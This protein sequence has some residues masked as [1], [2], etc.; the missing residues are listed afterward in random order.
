MAGEIE[1]RL[2]GDNSHFVSMLGDSERQA[3]RAMLGMLKKFD[4]RAGTMAI[5][6]AIG[7]NMQ[8]IADSVARAFTSMGK[9]AEAS[10]KSLLQLSE[11]TAKSYEQLFAARRTDAQNINMLEKENN[12]LANERLEILA[13]LE[14]RQKAVDEL[15]R[16]QEA[17]RKSKGGGLFSLGITN[18]EAAKITEAEKTRLEEIKNAE[19]KN[20]M[21]IEELRR[22]VSEDKK[23]AEEKRANDNEKEAEKEKRAEKEA[24]EDALRWADERAMLEARIAEQKYDTLSTE[25]KITAKTAEINRLTAEKMKMDKD[26]NDFLKVQVKI[27]E[28]NREL[29]EQ[30]AALAREKLGL[31]KEITSEITQQINI[32]G[33]GNKELSDRELD[34]KIST[35][36]KELA[37]TAVAPAAGPLGDYNP[38]ASM[39]RLDLERAIDEQRLRDQ[40]RR[41]VLRYGE[42]RAFRMSNLSE[43]RFQD[44][45]NGLQESLIQQ[46]ETN[47]LLKGGLRTL[48]MQTNGGLG[49]G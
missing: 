24:F 19:V 30:Q 46:R 10:L 41:N 27:N 26:S 20:M 23:R 44:I 3:D 33:R 11:Q 14:S 34:R 16:S 17:L 28:A 18:A 39:Q 6:T 15:N 37:Q 1:V 38:L 43:F 45:V 47:R 2:T 36:R 4:L 40:T 12:R 49:N 42:D 22:K 29:A 32:R 48:P 9:E 21:V 7:L 31:E 13:K 35:L 25:E 8:N 5:A